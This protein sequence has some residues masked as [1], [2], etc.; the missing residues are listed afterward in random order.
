MGDRVTESN[1]TDNAVVR[2]FISLWWALYALFAIGY[3][4]F[5]FDRGKST[6][7]HVQV[8]PFVL[9]TRW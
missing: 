5:P 4:C 7:V 1:S 8:E 3:P 2:P 6:T 9:K